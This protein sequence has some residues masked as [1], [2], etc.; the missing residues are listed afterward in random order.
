MGEEGWVSIFLDNHDFP[1]IVSRFGDDDQYRVE[2]A[3]LLAT[4]I[5]SLRGTPSIYQGTEIG[6]T[7]VAFPSIED[8]RDIETLNAYCQA[9]AN[10]EDLKQLMEGIYKQGRDNVRTPM[11][12]NAESN[13]GF[14]TGTP[15]IKLNP[16]FPEIN[17]EAVLNDPSSVF[18]YYQ[19]MLTFRKDNSTLIYG[20]YEQIDE[21][22]EQLYA[23]KR[24]DDSACYYVFLNFSA[25]KELLPSIPGDPKLDL[26]FGNYP[27]PEQL[28]APLGPW[29]ARIYKVLK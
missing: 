1:R 16:N 6:M 3:K 19:K 27:E 4:L 22:S 7:N 2:S 8:Y 11:H 10:G 28:L 9:E 18:Y 15:W 21:R 14:T 25:G 17:A 12:W 5:L 20:E 26:V 29:E 23:Y 24:W 13:A